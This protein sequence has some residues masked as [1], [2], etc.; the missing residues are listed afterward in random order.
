MPFGAE[1][2]AKVH[3]LC[4]AVQAC[5]WACFWMYEELKILDE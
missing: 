5:F 4:R 2:V 1:E 3:G